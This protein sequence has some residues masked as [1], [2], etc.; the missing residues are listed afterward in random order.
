MRI[1]LIL[2]DL[3]QGWIIQKFA[4]RM[5]TNLKKLGH[6]VSIQSVPSNDSDVNHFMSYNFV[7]PSPGVTTAMVTHIDDIF[8]ISHLKK[9]QADYHLNSLICMSA[10]TRNRLIDNGLDEKSISFVLPAVD[11]IPKHRT[12][13]IGLSGRVYPD[14]RKN[15]KWLVHVSKIINLELFE[16]HFFG[17]GWENTAGKLKLAN[18]TVHL[19]QETE[20][21]ETDHEN[22]LSSLPFLDFWMYLGFDEGSMGSLDA[23]L[24]G[25]PLI[26]TPQGFHLNLPHGIFKPVQ[27]EKDLLEVM[28]DLSEKSVLGPKDIL[29]W[30]WERYAAEH[31]KIWE[32]LYD[33]QGSQP[34]EQQFAR[35]YQPSGLDFLLESLD[36]V[37]IRSAIARS[38]LGLV[39][40]KYIKR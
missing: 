36:I 20:S 30:T 17:S 5:Q 14:G 28:K 33:F 9:I 6:T 35:I 24:A 39:F 18:A 27:N 31:I 15:E 38:K 29:H 4:E 13:K 37:R 16:F 22:I 26:A 23:A 11:R 7:I 32:G 40:R 2:S 12:I 8:K 10:Y 1:N 19:H 25:V 21:F 34:S 3:N